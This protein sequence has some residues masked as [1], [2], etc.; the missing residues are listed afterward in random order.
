MLEDVSFQTNDPNTIIHILNVAIKPNI[1]AIIEYRLSHRTGGSDSFTKII[2]G[3]EYRR[4]SV[5]DRY[6]FLY[7]ATKH[8]LQYVEKVEPEYI[9]RNYCLQNKDGSF[10]QIKEMKRNP[11]YT[12]LPP[13]AITSETL[14]ISSPHQ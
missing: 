11:S 2:E 1:H 8:N 12:G 9:E 7:I 10:R 6:L 3:D 13:I 4:W 5:D 14:N